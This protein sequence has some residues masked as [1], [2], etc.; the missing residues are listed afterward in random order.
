MAVLKGYIKAEEA[1]TILD[2]ETFRLFSEVIREKVRDTLATKGY[3]YLVM[4]P[5]TALSNSDD[6]YDE[7]LE[8]AKYYDLDIRRIVKE[9]K[10]PLCVLVVAIHPLELIPDD[11]LA[12]M[13][14]LK[15]KGY[16]NSRWIK[17]NSKITRIIACVIGEK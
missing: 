10:N 16:Y 17:A 3:S 4:N 7:A 13:P 2:L 11:F 1:N 6:I 15:Y 5:R 8:E 14:N 12:Y 9:V